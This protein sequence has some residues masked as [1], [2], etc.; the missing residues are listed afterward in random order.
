[1]LSKEQMQAN[2][3]TIISL[4]KSTGRKGV[5]NVISHLEEGDF[6]RVPAS[7]NHHNNFEGGLAKHSLDVYREA[8]NLYDDLT[9][10]LPYL[11]TVLNR[12]SL[13]LCSL[14]HDVC[15]MNVFC[16]RNGQSCK[17]GIPN[18]P[19]G[20]KSLKWLLDWGLELTEQ[21]QIAIAWHMGRWTKDAGCEPEEVE[22]RFL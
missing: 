6:F 4:L 16:I 1:M 19:H 22:Q 12:E 18:N 5:D 11:I 7:V 8:M 3:A 20:T 9:A 13:T 17:T 10:K 21:E 2:K 14:L 15:K